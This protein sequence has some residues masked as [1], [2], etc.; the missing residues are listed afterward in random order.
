[1]SEHDPGEV[2]KAVYKDHARLGRTT[3]RCCFECG[4]SVRPGDGGVRAYGQLFCSEECADDHEDANA[5]GL[6][7]GYMGTL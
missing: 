5:E 1:M 7:D 2:V 3:A 4:V 6:P